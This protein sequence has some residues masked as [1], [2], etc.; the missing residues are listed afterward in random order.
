VGFQRASLGTSSL[1]EQSEARKIRNQEIREIGE[2]R[3]LWGTTVHTTGSLKSGVRYPT[4]YL[5]PLEMT[6]KGADGGTL[7]NTGSYNVKHR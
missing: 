6:R 7:K 4:E 2:E 1:G 5:L 3:N